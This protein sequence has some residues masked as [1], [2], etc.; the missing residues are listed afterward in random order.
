MTRR[1]YLLKDVAR[2]L[3]VKPYR[4]AYALSVGLVP[5][6]QFRISNKRMFQRKTSQGL[7]STSRSSC[8]P[9]RRAGRRTCSAGRGSRWAVTVRPSPS[10]GSDHGCEILADGKVI[11]WTMDEP[12]A[13]VI[14]GLLDGAEEEESSS[15]TALHRAAGN[16]STPD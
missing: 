15:S 6:P 2:V 1:H 11:A 7:P 5:E 10:A 3:K 12:W 9:S 13:A 16:P 4:I 14:V 8:R